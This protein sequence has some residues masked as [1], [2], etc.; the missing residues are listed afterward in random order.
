M[1]VSSRVIASLYRPEVTK[2]GRGLGSGFA[3]EGGVSSLIESRRTDPRPES[4]PGHPLCQ[5]S[6]PRKARFYVAMFLLE[7]TSRPLVTLMTA[8]TAGFGQ[9]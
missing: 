6:V 9:D 8:S 7:R 5:A 3:C 4:G 1:R 2:E